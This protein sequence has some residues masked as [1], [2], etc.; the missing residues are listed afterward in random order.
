MNWWVRFLIAG[1]NGAMFQIPM[2]FLT[3]C[4]SYLLSTFFSILLPLLLQANKQLFAWKNE[5]PTLKEREREVLINFLKP[6]KT[7]P[8]EFKMSRS[9]VQF[10][11]IEQYYILFY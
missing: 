10:F 6:S 11:A 1:F 2:V 3:E 8:Q 7:K 5:P 9:I 4:L